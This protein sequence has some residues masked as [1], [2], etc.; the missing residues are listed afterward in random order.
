MMLRHLFRYVR[1]Y[2]AM[3][4]VL[5]AGLLVESGYGT[6]VKVSSKELI[7]EAIV[8]RRYDHLVLI[9]VV[10]AVGGVLSSVIAVGCDYLW[11]KFGGRVM[12]TVRLE[13][14]EHLQRLSMDFHSRSR[15]GDLMT[16]FTSDIGAI[17]MGLV[18]A[19]PSGIVAVMGILFS[20]ALLFRLE[21]RLAIL[22][23][24]CLPACVLGPKLLSP[25]AVAADYRYKQQEAGLASIVQENLSAQAVVKAFGLQRRAAEEFREQLGVF[26]KAE[27]RASFLTYLLQRTPN[28]AAL[29]ASLIV[30]GV[31][32]V[33]SFH[34]LLSVGSLVAFQVL[35]MGMSAAIG[36]LTSAGPYLVSA[37]G[38]MQRLRE[39][40]DEAPRV[41]NAARAT[42][43]PRL[44]HAIRFENV[45]FRYTP[46]E[47]GLR[48]VDLE[49][50]AG[51]RVALVGS[52]GS[53]KST[54][55][56]L[57]M[58]FYDPVEGRVCFDGT[59]LRTVTQESLRAQLAVVFQ[60]D[61]LFNISVRDNLRLGNPEAT[62]AELETAAKL[63][64][65]HTFLVAQ[66]NGYDELAGE[67]GSRFSGG[68][69]QRLALA[70]ALVRNPAVL[71][72]DEATSALDAGTE[73][74]IN[75]TLARISE[76]RTVISVTH[77]LASVVD[78]DLIV[79]CDEGR[80]V[81]LGTHE[82]LCRARG[83]YA[84]LWQKQHGVSVSAAHNRADVDSAWLRSLPFLQAANEDVL[85][86][87]RRMFIT[88]RYAADRVILQQGDLDDKF[89][90]IARGRVAVEG[91][92]TPG[93]S[94]F[95]AD[96]DYFG[97]I[98]PIKSVPRTATVRTVTMCTVL[99]LS[100]DQLR[101]V[102]PRIPGFEET[103]GRR[104]GTAT[105]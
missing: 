79:V 3:G 44:E 9:L 80:I 28:V 57:I 41:D 64:E 78:A 15:V 60:D 66:P 96:G 26:F 82:S 34:G 92:A 58:R 48:H 105:A 69:R 70:R 32:A 47:R 2:W 56:S 83:T 38:G 101:T 7:D 6:F 76:G 99:T 25:K 49:L 45:S 18:S 94:V 98:A 102:L 61:F 5:L 21:W 52:S 67:R 27:V 100:G 91:V 11:A 10:L 75:Q 24:I 43:L 85:A 74:A 54:L 89:F 90:I 42:T 13:L 93:E 81:E 59:D 39:V 68:Q 97:E 65:I 86:D 36:S 12:N 35:L 77:R 71:L 31:G 88:E 55:M 30:I 33:L 103:L 95:L 16:R 17:E 20:T 73:L 14:F 87:I 63:A 23:V 62:D 50:K 1:P 40:L 104:Y 72:L 37:A 51:T 53:G 4:F 19:L 29:L 46:Q 22:T 8:P 84:Q